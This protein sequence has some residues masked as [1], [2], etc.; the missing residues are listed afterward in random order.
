MRRMKKSRV[1]ISRLQKNMFFLAFATAFV[2]A[3]TQ[4]L[5]VLIDSLIVCT[6]YGETEIA[7]IA[8]AG[9]FFYLLEIP[10]AGL[11]AG[12]QVVCA[13]E[14]GAG[15]VDSVNQ[16]FNQIFL[17]SGIVLIVL[18]VLSFLSVPQMAVL[19]GAQG[20]TA[21]LQPYVMAY[22]YGLSFEI[23]PYVLFCIMAPVV[24]ID[25]GEKLISIASA[26]GCIVDIVLDLVS[27]RFGWGLWGIGLA[28]S[29]SAAVY[30]IMAML[31]FLNR[32]SVIKLRIERIHLRE[33]KDV[34]MSAA[35]KAFLSLADALRTTI[36]IAFVSYTGGVVGTCVLSIHGTINYMISIFA[37]GI[38]GAVGILSG[39]CCG[40]KNGEELEGIGV[41]AHR[42]ALILSVGVV[43]VLVMVMYPLSAA[44]T[45]NSATEELLI[46]AL[47]CLMATIPLSFLVQAR[48]GYLQAVGK[49]KEAQR[50]GIASNL[51]FLVAGACLLAPLFGVR[52]VFLAF[53]AS[54]LV[55]LICAWLKHSLRTKKRLPSRVDYLEVDESFFA[56]PGDVI[57]YPIETRDDCVIA[58]E[59]VVLF[60][61]GHKLDARKGYLAGLCMEELS[62]NVIEHGITHQQII[63]TAD[64]RVVIDN[65]DVI[66]RVRDGGR[67]FNL[68]SFADQLSK[69]MSD[70]SSGIGLKIL[71][72]S[73]K[74]VSY[75]RTF[76]MNTT[77][78]RV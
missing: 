35:P 43:I 20:K 58:S 7:A 27:V 15:K 61:K 68:K 28:S 71:L 14:L 48:I 13:R 34:F 9:P 10:A 46:F 45:E 39:I 55:T 77:I 42:Y 56:S 12:I 66:I 16:L 51:V 24:I 49:V 72:S 19:F 29:A 70:P 53:P 6:F 78:I 65:Q 22:L 4:T 47:Y 59:Q 69:E 38:A 41:L 23:I 1:Y 52:G 30:F 50:T 25:N 75:Y 8:V 40:E 5:A 74:S 57:S 67:P 54:Q 62:M 44:L 63:K 60:C 73:A 33:L 36:F 37:T 31:H 64:I 18:T 32:D 11:A 76:G 26:C 3:F 17:L 2:A 21:G